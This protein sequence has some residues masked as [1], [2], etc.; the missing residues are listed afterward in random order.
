V[1]ASGTP[2]TATGGALDV[3]IASGVTLEVNLDQNNDQVQVYGSDLTAPIATD[4]NGH[5]QVD[6]LTI[7]EIEIKNDVGN[8]IPVSDAGGSLT[9][10]G[11]VALDA[12]TLSA[13]ENITVQNGAGA[14][15]VNIQDGGNSITVDDGGGSITVDGTV[16]TTPSG[17]QDVNIISTIA[18]PVTDN[19]GSLTVDATNL[20][21]RDLVFATDKVDVTGST[22]TVQD[23]GGSITVD[24]TV[25]VGNFPTNVEISNDVGNPIPVNGTVAVTQTTSPWVV[26]GTV[27]AT[28]TGTQDVNIISTIA[29]PVTDNGGSLTVDGTVALDAG[30]LSALESITV[31]NGSGAA[32]VN[33]QDGGNSITVDGT[34][35]VGNFPAT[36][37]VAVT[38]IVE[39]EVKNDS[40]NPLPVSGTVTVNQPVA[41]TDNGGSLTVDGT[42]AATQS[43]T[44]NINNIS[45]TISLPTG[46]ATETTLAAVDTK[47]TAVV[48]TAG[49]IRP[50]AAGNVNT[51]A[52][53]FYSVSVANVGLTDG[54][55]LG[56]VI[57]P[58]EILNF[59]ADALNNYFT[60]FVYDATGTD[61]VI[62]F[63]Y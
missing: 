2:L 40:G 20:D 9:V 24:G 34:V 33:I 60:S 37:N 54:T 13:L 43:G 47:L 45:G 44:W 38:S 14:S 7:P 59:A 53:I 5:L 61:F 63:I 29:L 6:I 57:R 12:A 39:V 30:T 23:G 56:V 15:A 49:I 18:L 19:G 35:N 28:P 17:T 52:A 4:A 42:V 8:P 16:T 48:R 11:I 32:A 46:A 25:N 3:N 10:D 62:T 31:Q 22:V 41:V 26:S 55:V 50:T 27:T 51:V 36:Q 21:I 58:G 1:C